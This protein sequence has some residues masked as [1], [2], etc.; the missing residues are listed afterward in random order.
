LRDTLSRE[1]GAQ[2]TQAT[3][4]LYDAIRAGKVPEASQPVRRPEAPAPNNLPVP[5]TSFV[6]RR[7]EVLT[8]ERSLSMTRLMTLTGTGGSGKTRLALE[9]ARGLVGTY[10]EGVWLAE[11]APLSDPGLVAR[12]V[13][14]TLGVREHPQLTLTQAI[15]TH[16]G[17][18]RTLLVLDN[19][20]HLVGAAARFTRDLLSACEGLTVLATSREP[21]RVSGEI[22]WPVPTLSLPDP[23][24]SCNVE[25][26]MSSEAV[27]LFVDRA[28]SRLPA[29]ELKRENSDAVASVC[30]EL[31]GIPLAIEL[32]TARMGALAVEQIVE[33]LEGSLKLLSGGDRTVAERHQTL[34]AT[35]DWSYDLLD[36]PERV[37]FRRLSVFAGGWPL[38]AAEVVGAGGIEAGEVLNLLSRLVDKSMVVAGPSEG[39]ALRYG[40]L[41]PVR[42]YG[43]EH[44]AA[45]GE[46][47]AVRRRHA[48]WYYRLAEEVEPWLRGAR[49]EVW[50][51]RLEREY[52]NLRAALGWALDKGEMDLGLWFGGALGEFWYM[53]G[54]L[55]EG[56]RWLEAALAKS[57]GAPQTP[58]RS[59]ALLRAGWIAWE[60]GDYEDSVALSEESLAQSRELGDRAGSVA[61][62]S[63]LGWA[64]LLADH[65]RRASALAHEAVELARTIGD[66]GGVARALLI[67][68]LAAVAEGDHQQA[69][70]L[71]G[72]SLALARGAEDG[73]AMLISL[74]MGAFASLGLEDGP[75]ARA[76]CAQSLALPTQPRVANAT[77]FQLHASAALACWEGLSLRSARLWGAAESLRETVGATLSPIELRVYR[78]YIEAARER[79][80]LSAWN[81]AL[82]EG[83]AMTAD[84]A[85]EYATS[86]RRRPRPRA[87]STS[88]DVSA[89]T[90]PN[91]MLTRR[92]R[93][94]AFLVASG[95][96]NRQIASELRISENTVANHVARILRKLD[97]SSRSRIAIWVRDND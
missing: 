54:N 29:F 40:M 74:A 55:G 31:D 78:P 85:V 52:G 34:R 21:L 23:A 12:A 33:R 83:R 92:Q 46:A 4:S 72:E 62:L 44:L 32:S 15:C 45:S 68:G 58:A 36:E 63:N 5:L 59:R 60:Q 39:G 93:E 84:E 14:T 10:A 7:K 42:R 66:T 30:R 64:A 51:E 50:L 88:G 67:P 71:H 27:R 38:E 8:V 22:V 49:Q 19:C 80:D 91:G 35:L 76:L 75:R 77:A 61:A 73:I 3:R 53:S 95:L 13:A 69:L 97:A 57:V 81:E 86:D 94:V 26:L 6:G 9:V 90:Q 41:E 1:L 47:E 82:A 70:A 18:G 65:P 96:T 79:L 25:D 87:A 89:I 28:S 48:H 37:L 11:L 16:L 2:P 56:R 24:S 17:S 43:Q 20:E